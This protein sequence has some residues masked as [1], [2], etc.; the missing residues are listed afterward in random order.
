MFLCVHTYC[1]SFHLGFLLT[2]EEIAVTLVFLKTR[3]LPE[4]G[5]RGVP[6]TKEKEPFPCTSK[7]SRTGNAVIGGMSEAEAESKADYEGLMT[8]DRL[9][10]KI[11]ARSADIFPARVSCLTSTS[12]VKLLE[13]DMIRHLL[14]FTKLH[15][16]YCRILQITTCC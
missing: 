16:A 4:A 5:T 12:P 8:H 10:C 9:P 13:V 3:L 14:N 6:A 7:S 1:C 11:R 15:Y 2:L